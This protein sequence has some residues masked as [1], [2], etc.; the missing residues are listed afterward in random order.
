MNIVVYM[1]VA[2]ITMEEQQELNILRCSFLRT[3]SP[4]VWLDSNTQRRNLIWFTF[5]KIFKFTIKLKLPSVS[6][7]QTAFSFHLTRVTPHWT[8][9]SKMRAFGDNQRRPPK[10][11]T[12]L[13]HPANSVKASVWLLYGFP[14]ITNHFFVL[15]THTSSSHSLHV[16]SVCHFVLV[17][18]AFTVLDLVS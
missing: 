1:G 14:F 3:N 15:L 4:E 8:W 11:A 7:L 2:L 13:Y 16:S 18:F 12:P 6:L 9:L 5:K 10:E 17:L